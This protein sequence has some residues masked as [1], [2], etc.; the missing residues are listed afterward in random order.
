MT[1]LGRR[2]DP[3]ISPAC[4]YVAPRDTNEVVEVPDIEAQQLGREATIWSAKSNHGATNAIG[5]LIHHA[6]EVVEEVVHPKV[7]VAPRGY[8]ESKVPRGWTGLAL[9]LPIGIRDGVQHTGHALA[10]KGQLLGVA[11]PVPRKAFLA[12]IGGTYATAATMAATGWPANPTTV[13]YWGSL[14]IASVGSVVITHGAELLRG[15]AELLK[16]GRGH[17][18]LRALGEGVVTPLSIC[19]AGFYVG[20]HMSPTVPEVDW[21]SPAAAAWSSLVYGFTM[22]VYA[23]DAPVV[24]VT[25]AREFNATYGERLRSRWRKGGRSAVSQINRRTQS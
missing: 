1:R 19:Y 18:L 15:V 13:F 5:E 8:Q 3:R 14:G 24:G 17:E 12:G 20:H 4:H 7:D 10:R 6:G 25:A 9:A 11:I 22:T 23:G 16:R 2:L 21:S